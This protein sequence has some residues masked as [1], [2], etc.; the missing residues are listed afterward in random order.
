MLG[1]QVVCGAKSL[2]FEGRDIGQR[3]GKRPANGRL[4]CTS[5]RKNFIPYREGVR[6]LYQQMFVHIVEVLGVKLDNYTA[7]TYNFPFRQ[8]ISGTKNH[9]LNSGVVRTL[10]LS[11]EHIQMDD[12]PVARLI[13]LKWKDQPIGASV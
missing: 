3:F 8:E 6:V 1:R 12:D 7:A 4:S 10:F 5:Q 2:G 11:V 13:D 9:L